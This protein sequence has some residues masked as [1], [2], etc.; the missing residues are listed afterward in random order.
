MRILSRYVLA[1]FLVPLTYCLVTFVSLY[2]MIELVDVYGDI[3]AAKPAPRVVLLYFVGYIAPL[4]EWLL[5]AALLL[6]SLYTMWQLCRHSEVTAM[7]ASGLGLRT[8]IGPMV[9]VAVVCAVLAALNLEF[10]AP[11]VAEYA[12]RVK[13]ED[14]RSQ[15]SDVRENI[16]Y[17]NTAGRRIWRIARMDLYA[18]ETLDEVQ[19]TFERSDG[20]R[21]VDITC[22]RVEYMDGMWWFFQPQ[23]TW[24]DEI[25][26]QVAPV[27]PHLANLQVRAM[28]RLSETP[29][30][31]V[32]ETR[33]WSFLPV[34]ARLR[35]LR[36]HPNLSLSERHSKW[37]DIHYRLAAPWSGVVITLFAIPMGIATGRQS[38]FKGI[39]AAIGLF[40][41]FFATVN[42]GMILAKREL[43][44]AFLG[45]W[46][47]HVLFLVTGLVLLWRQR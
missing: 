35:Y 31:F 16:N 12:K 20:T 43:I 37:Y 25:G 42:G 33:E 13:K 4:F 5:A 23:Y 22:K 17:Y 7:R 11:S 34:L 39:L 38:V 9:G 28:P 27:L 3:V 8:I 44:P 32:N 15:G 10:F 26:I 24:Y 40:F 19:I 29:N 21:E 45:A 1:A 18:P 46:L 30:D 2:V 14:F 6:A 47:P 41:A 36:V